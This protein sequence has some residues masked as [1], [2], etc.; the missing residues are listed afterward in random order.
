MLK[1]RYLL[2]LVISLFILTQNLSANFYKD[3]EETKN[4]LF[5]QIIDENNETNQSI[6]SSDNLEK[7]L[8]FYNEIITTI[9]Q[10]PYKLKIDSSDF[11]NYKEYNRD[12]TILKNRIKANSSRGNRLAI[13]R[14]QI[15]LDNLYIKAQIH[16]LFLKLSKY[17]ALFET[18][19]IK[20][21][22]DLHLQ[23]LQN[24]D[25]EKYE[26]EVQKLKNSK[27]SVAIE[28]KK[29]FNHLKPNYD[30]YDDFLN[31]IDDN[32]D[33]LFHEKSLFQKLEFGDLIEKINNIEIFSKLNVI[34]RY[35][36][37]DSGKLLIFLIITILSFILKNIGQTIILPTLR[38]ILNISS[39]EN[40][41]ITSEDFEKLKSPLALIIKTFGFNIA[42]GVLFYPNSMSETLEIAFYT[43]YLFAFAKILITLIDILINIYFDTSS[44]KRD[45]QLRKEL[46]RFIIQM[47]K[48]IIII[49]A[50]LLFL[51][52]V[53]VDITAFVASL[54]LG[55]LVIAMASKDTI[56]NF[57]G[58]LK[59]IFDESFSQGDW[60]KVSNAE[61]TVVQLGFISTKIRTFDN[62]LI[63]I[64]NALI[65]NESVKNWDRRKVGRRI[66]MYI[67]VSYNAN[68][69]SLVK[70]VDEIREMLIEHPQIATPT[71]I[72][73]QRR[74]SILFDINEAAGIKT[75]LLVHID[76]FA[77]SSINILVY[78]FSKTVKW[79][80]W[81]EVKQDIMLKIWE[82]LENNNLEIAF[83]TQTIHIE[84][85]HK[86]PNS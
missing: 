66:K 79:A 31:Y 55:G 40:F 74:K 35:I 32:Q 1:N 84:K 80:Q 86:A 18:E 14:D 5:T 52:K 2:S 78:T 4:I 6:E 26:Q 20:D 22:I 39:P 75:T 59:I 17:F 16:S 11:F 9:K 51:R 47:T 69:E 45:I 41:I 61:G 24:I 48:A 73:Q 21:I 13:I 57:F 62:A 44:K 77:D 15:A 68:R 63:S 65:A 29:N 58:S 28:L 56:S 42:L 38:K 81:L 3:F 27:F 70:A 30:F 53:G 37:I 46:V 19:K 12:K 50:F 34:L 85:S 76:E 71:K 7:K 67:G 10:K 83:P 54:G 33:K 72:E 43:I 36:Y 82:I 60:I 25:I 64:P 8:H 23:N 49:V